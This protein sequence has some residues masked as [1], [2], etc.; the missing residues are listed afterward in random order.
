MDKKQKLTLIFGGIIPIV[1][2]TVIEDQWGLMAGLIAAI[3]YAIG[4]SIYELMK[5][6]TISKMTIYSNG[7]IIGLGL[8]SVLFNDGIWFKLQPAIIELVF[9]ILLMVTSFQG[10]PLLVTMVQQQQGEIKNNIMLDFLKSLNVRLA[11][12][13]LLHSIL[14]VWA[15]FYWSTESW[16]LLKG[17][18]LTLSMFLYVLAE[19]LLLRL[20]FKKKSGD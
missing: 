11:F 19:I 10:R 8:I 3:I 6:R 4:E 12:F 17:V 1:L 18:G 20:R 14:A 15:A 7:L 16:A 5:Y 2:F 13:F 9:F